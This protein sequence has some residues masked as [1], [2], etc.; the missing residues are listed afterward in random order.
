MAK[1]DKQNRLIVPKGL[2]EISDT[3]FKGNV[4][5]FFKGKEFF[6]DNPSKK[7]SRHNCLGEIQLDEHNRFFVPKL[8]RE[9]LNLKPGDNIISY[10]QYGKVTFKKVFFIPENR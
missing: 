3:D 7:N 10:V 5:L 9:V 8:A 6:L 1:L 2:I 4:Q